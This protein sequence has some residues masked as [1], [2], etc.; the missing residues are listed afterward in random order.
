[1]VVVSKFHYCPCPNMPYLYIWYI[2]PMRD[3]DKILQN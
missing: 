3:N 2:L 1:V